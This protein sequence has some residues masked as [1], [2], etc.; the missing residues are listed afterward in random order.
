M[1]VPVS[2]ADWALVAGGLPLAVFGVLRLRKKHLIED[3]PTSTI[4]GVAMGMAELK[5]KT[6]MRTPMFSLLTQA[7]C[8]WWKFKVEEE[9][10][11][12]KGGRHWVTVSSGES[13]DIFHLE[14]GTA[15]IAVDPMGAE[16]RIENRRQW[17]GGLVFG[18]SD[19]FPSTY[20]RR[21]TEWLIL[22]FAPLYVYGYVKGNRD[23]WAD[24]KV[25]LTEALRAL[26]ADKARL[27]SFDR[28]G[29]GR[30][31]E[32]EWAEAVKA[33]ERQ[34]AEE[35]LAAPGGGPDPDAMM[36]CRGQVE[37]TY[38][39]SDTG[40]DGALR[41]LAWAGYGCLAAGLLVSL[42][43]AQSLMAKAGLWPWAWAIGWM[44]IF[45]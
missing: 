33:V 5:G 21:Y 12:G 37:R 43:G 28:D 38:I 45:R 19:I 34:L 24:R 31:N 22:P 23:A 1:S 39:I 16:M 36:V 15:T 7:P 32:N 13:N 4:R 29:D 42:L 17:R 10:E 20:E 27:A 8:V 2:W 41:G 44:G 30:I 3:T 6:R 9:R 35:D 26:K 11:G 14:D 25:R 18:N 40:E